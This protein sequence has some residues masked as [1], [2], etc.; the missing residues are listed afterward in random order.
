MCMHARSVA[1]R[2]TITKA[3]FPSGASV[4]FKHYNLLCYV[5]LCIVKIYYVRY[6]DNDSA[7]RI[8][9]AAFSEYHTPELGS[10]N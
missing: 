6:S 1:R 8:L 9:K 10:M 7:Q 5:M 4:E 3:P 2:F